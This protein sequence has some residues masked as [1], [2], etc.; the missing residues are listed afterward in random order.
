MSL[1]HPPGTKAVSES[2][3]KGALPPVVGAPLMGA[4]VCT[5]SLGKEGTEKGCPYREPRL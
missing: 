4:L 3:S 1:L 2:R 5:G